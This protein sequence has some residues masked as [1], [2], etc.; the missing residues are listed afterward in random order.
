MKKNRDLRQCLAH[1]RA[2]HSNNNLRPEQKDQIGIVIDRV[3]EL[4]RKRNPSQAEVFACVKEVS[5]RLLRVSLKN[6]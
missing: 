6:Y 1:L 5:E 4:G 2:S 3:K